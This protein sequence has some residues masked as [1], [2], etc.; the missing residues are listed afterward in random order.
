MRL[1]SSKRGEWT[2]VELTPVF[3]LLLL[4]GIFFIPLMLWMG[5]TVPDKAIYERSFLA[6]DLSMALDALQASPNNALIVYDNTQHF[7]FLVTDNKVEVFD[8]RKQLNPQPILRET[9]LYNHNL[10]LELK[11]ADVVRP[12][13]VPVTDKKEPK[14]VSL[15]MAKSGDALLIGDETLD[16]SINTRISSIISTFKEKAIIAL[17]T[18]SESI[19]KTYSSLKII[20]DAVKLHTIRRYT[21][22]QRLFTSN[23]KEIIGEQLDLVIILSMNEES[24]NQ[25]KAWYYENEAKEKSLKFINLIN[26][27][28]DVQ[29]SDDAV[30]NNQYPTIR[31][32]FN[33]DAVNAIADAI[34]NY[35][36]K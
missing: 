5:T 26:L 9:Y 3:L 36:K 7:S 29:Q 1:L 22:S 15:R 20:E 12:Q 16:Y 27:Q 19:D 18:D 17:L 8:E 30:L 28:K 13:G 2:E 11:Q 24:A 14:S 33:K 6:R 34:N 23:Y 31:I 21:P 10:N 4:T 32:E 35:F 25:I